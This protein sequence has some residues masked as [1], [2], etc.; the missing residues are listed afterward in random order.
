MTGNIPGEKRDLGV[1]L[2]SNLYLIGIIANLITLETGETFSRLFF[3][4]YFLFFR[5]QSPLRRCGSRRG[6]HTFSSLK[7]SGGVSSQSVQVRRH[8]HAKTGVPILRESPGESR[9]FA[10]CRMAFAVSCRVQALA[11]FGTR[12]LAFHQMSSR[13]PDPARMQRGKGVSTSPAASMS[14]PRSTRFSGQ[15][16]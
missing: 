7:A 10:Q 8:P 12:R 16:I 6:R 3:W 11:V 1:L 4:R 13:M 15:L 5:L 14:A 2:V 9:T